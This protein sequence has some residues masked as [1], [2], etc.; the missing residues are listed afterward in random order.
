[1]PKGGVDG[2]MDEKEQ[3]RGSGLKGERDENEQ[4]RG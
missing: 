3:G 4:E 2:V 1:M